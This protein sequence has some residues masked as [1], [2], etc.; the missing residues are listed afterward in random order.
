M[1]LNFLFA[2]PKYAGV[3][4]IS[5]V[6]AKMVLAILFTYLLFKVVEVVVDVYAMQQ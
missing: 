4:L 2:V 3:A 5:T 1:V 6:F